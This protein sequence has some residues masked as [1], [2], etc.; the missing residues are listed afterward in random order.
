MAKKSAALQYMR[1]EVGFYVVA[2]HNGMAAGAAMCCWRRND[3]KSVA[4]F[5][6]CSAVIRL[7]VILEPRII[8]SNT[9][10]ALMTVFDKARRQ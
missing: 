9:I 5:R 3:Q 6:L 10:I 4:K 7:S 2:L 1:P 8:W